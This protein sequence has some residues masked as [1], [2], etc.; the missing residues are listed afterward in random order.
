MADA[1]FIP[2]GGRSVSGDALAVVVDGDGGLVAVLDGPDDVIGPHAA[3]PPKK[4]PG[5]VHWKVALSTLG[6]PHLSNSMPMSRS[7]Q[8]NAPSCPMARMTASA[9][10]KTVSMTL[11]LVSCPF[12][13]GDHSSRSNTMPLSLPSS[14]TNDLGAWLTM[15]SHLLLLGVLELPGR[16]LE[17][18]AGAA[19]HD[20]DVLAAE[21]PRGA[22]A[23]H[24]GVADADDEHALL[25]RGDVAEG[26]AV[27]PVDAD[28]DLVRVV[29]AGD[30]QVL[31]P[32]GAG[33]DEDGVELAAVEQRPSCSRW[34]CRSGCRRPSRR[35][36]SISSLST[37]SGRRKAGMLERI[38]PPGTGSFSKM[39]TS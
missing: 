7:I 39:V 8:G 1:R 21:A 9:G 26:D 12:S 35:I 23:V 22:A 4:T 14:M 18:G 37:F 10:M 31:A 2:W 34:A 25:D 19:G 15:I 32:G 17:V 27:E 11:L 20:L 6:M 16:G 36:M 13:S 38:R 24:G 30:L 3:S 28:V 29:A 33:A 5:R